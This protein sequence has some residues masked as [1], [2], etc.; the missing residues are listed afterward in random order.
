VET[1]G[2]TVAEDIIHEDLWF[3]QILLGPIHPA[4]QGINLKPIFSKGFRLLLNRHRRSPLSWKEF[5]K[6]LS[7]ILFQIN[8]LHLIP[9]EG[10][11]SPEILVYLEGHG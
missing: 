10:G 4:S 6:M 7:N 11:I 8:Q 5:M 2:V 1:P 9:K 3:F